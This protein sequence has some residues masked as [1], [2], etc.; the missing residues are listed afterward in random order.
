MVRMIGSII[1]GSFV[2]A[3]ILETQRYGCLISLTQRRC[4]ESCQVAG[5]TIPK[6]AP[7]LANIYA[8]HMDPKTFT[9]PKRFDP[10]RFLNDDGDKN[11]R[12]NLLVP[13]GIGK[14]QIPWGRH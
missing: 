11:R 14:L 7:V 12:E 1:N 6:G 9:N 5:Y 2:E 4:V 3:V 10:N 13:F 8:A